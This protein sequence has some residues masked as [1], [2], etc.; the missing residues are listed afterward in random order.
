[1]KANNLH[2]SPASAGRAHTN[3]A[4]TAGVIGMGSA[5]EVTALAGKHFRGSRVAIDRTVY[6]RHV[7]WTSKA[8]REHVLYLEEVARLDALIT[9]ATQAGRHESPAEFAHTSVDAFG[10][11]RIVRA[12]FSNASTMKTVPAG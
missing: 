6:E 8:M 9:A 7:A 4:N 5:I 11:R 10:H 2:L 1:M 12:L 3:L